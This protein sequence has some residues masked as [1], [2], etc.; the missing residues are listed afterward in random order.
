MATPYSSYRQ[1][2]CF[3]CISQTLLVGGE[4][5]VQAQSTVGVENRLP[6]RL[7]FQE[8][9][10]PPKDPEP[11]K[12]SSSGSR[13]GLRCSPNEQPIQPLMPKRNY[14]LTFEE[15]PPV[16]VYLPKTSAKQVELS[17]RDEAGTYQE[18]AFL[19]ITNSGKIVH[20]SLPPDKSP[21]TIGK[22]YQWFLVVVCGTT[23]QPDDPTFQGWVQPVARTDK[24]AKELSQKPPIW[25]AQWYGERG[26]WYDMLIAIEQ[27]QNANSNNPQ[28]ITLL[29][30]FWKS[31]G[32]KFGHW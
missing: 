24:V 5:I 3:L 4:R 26:Y 13:D 31:V 16:F 32:L 17:I 1:I 6:E 22:N 21:L 10:Q 8:S 9:F 23:A 28:L 11:K 18:S 20:F 15:H 30:E 27:A 7:V 14:G 2:V 29:Q 19:P 25:Q 12:T